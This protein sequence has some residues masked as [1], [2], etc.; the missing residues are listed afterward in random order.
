LSH[1]HSQLKTKYAIIKN[2][3][4]TN[5]S[6]NNTQKETIHRKINKQYLEINISKKK[7]DLYKEKYKILVG[8][9][10]FPPHKLLEKMF[11]KI[12]I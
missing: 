5:E 6:E 7:V 9:F 11:N 12:L 4:L 8:H 1:E 3:I 10:N 2:S